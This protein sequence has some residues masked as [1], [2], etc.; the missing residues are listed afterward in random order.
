MTGHDRVSVNQNGSSVQ[1]YFKKEF[2]QDTAFPLESGEVCIAYP[3]GGGVHILPVSALDDA[4]SHFPVTIERP[5]AE[6]IPPEHRRLSDSDAF[7]GDGDG[8]QEATATTTQPD[9]DL[10]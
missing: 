1:L 5:P 8:D 7:D 10:R 9:N 4:E 6:A 2:A 3:V